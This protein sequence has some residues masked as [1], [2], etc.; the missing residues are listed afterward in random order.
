MPS[1]F[2]TVVYQLEIRSRKFNIFLLFRRIFDL[3]LRK[4]KVLEM[5]NRSFF[6]YINHFQSLFIFYFLFWLVTN[7]TKRL[8]S[9][10]IVPGYQTK[11]ALGKCQVSLIY[12]KG[13]PSVSM[14]RKGGRGPRQ[15]VSALVFHL[16]KG[17]SHEILYLW[18]FSSEDPIWASFS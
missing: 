15:F 9:C 14:S 4:W 7:S 2:E 1:L 11:I 5:L 17:Q 18:F 10:C 8:F 6:I 3:C 16:L 13:G 12:T